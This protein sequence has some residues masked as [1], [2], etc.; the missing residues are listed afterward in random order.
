MSEC[1]HVTELHWSSYIIVAVIGGWHV[2]RVPLTTHTFH[3]GLA[4]NVR[5]VLQRQEGRTPKTKHQSYEN[6]GNSI[7]S[8]VVDTGVVGKEAAGNVRRINRVVAN[9]LRARLLQMSVVPGSHLFNRSMM[10]NSRWD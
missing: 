5:V 6:R 1:I 2:G 4:V 7:F 3:A 8:P 10:F 9:V